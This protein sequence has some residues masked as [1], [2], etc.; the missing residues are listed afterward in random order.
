MGLGDL[1]RA[2]ESGGDPNARNPNS[3]A[4]IE[5]GASIASVSAPHVPPKFGV[6]CISELLLAR[7]PTAVLGRIGAV[8]VNSINGMSLRWFQ[9]HVGQ[10]IR[11]AFAPALTNF[12]SARPVP[13]VRDVLLVLASGDHAA[14]RM[15]FSSGPPVSADRNRS[16]VRRVRFL[17]H[18]D[19]VA[20]AT[21]GVARFKVGNGGCG[22][23]PAIAL[24]K[25]SADCCTAILADCWLGL[26]YG[27]KLS[28]SHS[29]VVLA[30]AH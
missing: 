16:T 29:G 27:E 12:D 17:G 24:A 28:K 22:R 25:H 30:G 10:K 7:C 18:F 2:A 4:S 6:A 13:S 20:S 23:V 5:R 9:S 11:E 1:I 21:Q 3:S 8:A 26:G 14:P 15:I 19:F